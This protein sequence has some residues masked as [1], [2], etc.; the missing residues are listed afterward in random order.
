MGMGNKNKKTPDVSIQLVQH[1]PSLQKLKISNFL[2]P[3]YTKNV[4]CSYKLKTLALTKSDLAAWAWPRVPGRNTVFSNQFGMSGLPE[5]WIT[6]DELC[7]D[8]LCFLFCLFIQLSFTFIQLFQL[9][10]TMLQHC[11]AVMLQKCFGDYETSSTIVALGWD[12][13]RIF[14]FGWT[15]PLKQMARQ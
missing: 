3:F 6:P 2:H 8:V 15:F 12:N 13:D 14:I 9:L 7:G 4:H 10:R 5:A 1:N 11:F